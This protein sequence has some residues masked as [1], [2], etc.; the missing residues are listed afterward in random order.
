[1]FICAHVVPPSVLFQ[2]PLF[3]G[4]RS[5]TIGPVAFAAASII[6]YITLGFA[7]LMSSVMRPFC[8]A[9]NPPP[10]TSAQV[11]PPSVLFQS[12]EPGPP[13]NSEYGVRRRSQLVAKTTFGSFG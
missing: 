13:L 9:G 3:F 6:M 5:P 4:L 10:F 1:M 7:A 12:A 2:S 8:P 11:V